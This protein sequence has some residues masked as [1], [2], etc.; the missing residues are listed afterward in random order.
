MAENV[1]SSVIETIKENLSH[2]KWLVAVNT[3]SAEEALILSNKERAKAAESQKK[4][5]ELEAFLVE[6]E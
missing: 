3:R 4:V 5:D 2:E 1:K 6:N